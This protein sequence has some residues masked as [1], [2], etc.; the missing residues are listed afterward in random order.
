MFE[1]S[2]IWHLR[3]SESQRPAQLAAVLHAEH[4]CAP[5]APISAV[6][7]TDYTVSQDL[8]N[9]GP[10]PEVGSW[11]LLWVAFRKSKH[12]NW[13]TVM[14]NFVDC[15]KLPELACDTH[16]CKSLLV[17]CPVYL[18]TGSTGATLLYSAGEP[19]VLC[20]QVNVVEE[21]FSLFLC[22]WTYFYSHNS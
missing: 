13:L 11:A 21:F 2:W 1:V 7:V 12:K 8:P 22:L 16:S 10:R 14:Q 20:C 18:E 5:D 4:C 15:A 9:H 3:V 19:S 6:D 17:F